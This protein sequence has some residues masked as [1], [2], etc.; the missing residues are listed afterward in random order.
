MKLFYATLSKLGGRDENED[1]LGVR[2]LSGGLG[3]W[4]VADGL[5]GHGAGETASGLAVETV[6]AAFAANPSLSNTALIDWVESAQ[7]EILDRQSTTQ[8]D[9]AMCTAIT[10]FCSDGHRALWAQVGD[11]RVYVFR[12]GAAF[13]P[14]QDHSAPQTS[15]PVG[16]IGNSGIRRHEDRNRQL[17][18]L[19]SPAKFQPSVLENPFVILKGDIF[20]ICTDG[21][22]ECVT[23]LEM[24]LEW[25]KSLNLRDWLDRMELRL[26]KRAPLA[27][28]NYSAIA[29]LADIDGD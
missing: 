28:D 8:L 5:G 25:S 20:L 14:T 19:G 29:L 17:R 3:C 21:F 24:M 11:V 26:L 7:G 1:C 16:D 15:A 13:L 23:E 4:V 10:V 12:D 18:S 22:W 9:P 27:L 2:L 6:L